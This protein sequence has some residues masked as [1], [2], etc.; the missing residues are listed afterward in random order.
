LPQGGRAPQR[1]DDGARL[2]AAE[3]A[4]DDRDTDRAR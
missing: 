4:L 3:W 2:L 1:A